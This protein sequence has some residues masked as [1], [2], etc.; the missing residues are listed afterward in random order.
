MTARSSRSVSPPFPVF[1]PRK[2]GKMHRDRLSSSPQVMRPSVSANYG[3][4]LSAAKT[5]RI[6]VGRLVLG[7]GVVMRGN[8]SIV[9]WWALLVLVLVIASSGTTSAQFSV[10]TDRSDRPGGGMRH[11]GTRDGG[12]RGDGMRDNG[13]G[14][15]IGIDIG[16]AIVE[17]SAEDDA[18]KKSGA[19]ANVQSKT[20]DSKKPKRAAKKGDGNTPVPMNP[21][22]TPKQQPPTT[23]E[24]PP[25]TTTE[26]PPTKTTGTPPTAGDP[27]PTVVPPTAA[28]PP[29]TSPPD[30]TTTTTKTGGPVS[31]PGQPVNSTI[32]GTKDCPQRGMGCAV[33]ILDYSAKTGD[34]YDLKK[35]GNA[36][37]A[38][39][40]AVEFVAP[41]FKEMPDAGAEGV[42]TDMLWA[43]R[44]HNESEQAAVTKAFASHRQAV[45]KGVE[46]AVEML[47]GHGDEIGTCGKVGPDDALSAGESRTEIH[48]GDYKA[49]LKNTCTWYVADLTC[50]SGKTPQAVDELNNSGGASCKAVP[51]NNCALH[52][53]YDSDIALGAATAKETCT[54]WRIGEITK[55]FTAALNAEKARRAAANSSSNLK[56]LVADLQKDSAGW[57]GWLSHYTDAGYKV[58]TPVTRE[59]YP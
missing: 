19:G 53:A 49:A 26:G 40:C 20:Q 57:A 15:G 35:T 6:G 39:G 30:T 45:A 18:R 13:V 55:N 29:P 16:R 12:M 28:S 2:E 51:G 22:P 56:Q 42:T 10:G 8:K 17:K 4:P 34:E 21:P 7:P 41:V 31:P 27:P 43:V 52:A 50:Y 48:M 54:N 11:E 38:I 14:I 1:V 44:R 47:N 32:T 9:G 37:K 33:L 46:L 58:C 3:R 59:G 24:T 5:H 25:P 23:T 36:F